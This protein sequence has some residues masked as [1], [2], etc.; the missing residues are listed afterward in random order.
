MQSRGRLEK[1]VRRG[2]EG[3][4]EVFRRLEI[5]CDGWER[6]SHCGYGYLVPLIP[7][8]KRPRGDKFGTLGDTS[9]ILACALH[10]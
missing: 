6:Y 1:T 4:K 3:Y 10:T 5:M 9:S 7:F 2:R 8:L